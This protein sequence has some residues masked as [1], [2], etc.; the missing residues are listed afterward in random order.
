MKQKPCYVCR[1]PIDV[2]T[3]IFYVFIGRTQTDNMEY[4]TDCYL[5][6]IRNNDK[7]NPFNNIKIYS[8]NFI[9]MNK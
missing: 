8:R 2:D 9:R 4:C 1:K 3:Q 5:Q 6:D 7:L